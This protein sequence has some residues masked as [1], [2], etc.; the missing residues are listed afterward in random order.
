MMVTGALFLVAGTAWL[1]RLD[2]GDGYVPA[3]LGP[4]ALLGL[5][6]GCSFV[7]ASA[8]ILAS[9]PPADSGAASGTLQ[10]LQ[11]VGGAIGL[12]VLATAYTAAGGGAGGTAAA[13]TLASGLVG[14]SLLATAL[15]V[16]RR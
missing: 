16:R 4:M 8:T 12:A 14:V 9:V 13:F 5:G 6:V 11:Q 7:P 1:S 2:A 15:L 10:T 3:V